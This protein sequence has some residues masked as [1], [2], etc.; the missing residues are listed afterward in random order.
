MKN[1]NLHRAFYCCVR[2]HPS[3]RFPERLAVGVLAN[4]ALTAA[5][6]HAG[7]ATAVPRDAGSDVGLVAP[8]RAVRRHRLQRGDRATVE[9]RACRRKNSG[10]ENAKSDTKF[11][12]VET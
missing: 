11:T 2:R 3:D 6:Q 12:R 7:V 8:A 5:E 4:D 9:I 10:R 1:L